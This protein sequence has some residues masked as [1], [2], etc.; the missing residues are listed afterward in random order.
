M[1]FKYDVYGNK[2]GSKD[3]KTSYDDQSSYG[4]QRLN[5]EIEMRQK[6]AEEHQNHMDSSKDIDHSYN[7][8][9]G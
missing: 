6:I 8:E 5:E 9:N 7:K 4:P 3:G 1:S 2:L